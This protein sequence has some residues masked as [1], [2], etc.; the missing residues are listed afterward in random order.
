MSNDNRRELTPRELQR[1]RRKEQIQRRRLVAALVLIGLIIIIIVLVVTCSGSGDE[2]TTTT[3][4][5]PN[6]ETTSTT[7]G[8]ATYTA[9]L[10]G[11]NSVP[12]VETDASGTLEMK[13]DPETSELSYT[14]Q[15]D[16][17]TAPS[18]AAIY[19][20]AE[21]VSGTVVYTL[22]AGPAE[23][24][25]YS[26][27]LAQDTIDESELTGSL[28]GGTVADLIALIN[29]GN[30]YVSVGTTQTPVDR[31]RGQIAESTVTTD[32]SSDTG[33]TD[34]TDESDTTSSDTT[35]TTE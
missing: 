33:S 4:T 27:V 6:G 26:G 13:Y 8:A 30:A 34:T 29:E 35:D 12:A 10:S 14:L 7:L 3:T 17:L 2:G 20:G 5:A 28:E 18:S 31:I 16:G 15:V 9:D 11:D 21:G 25:D 19:E 32:T 24:G 23:K 1:Q 22:F